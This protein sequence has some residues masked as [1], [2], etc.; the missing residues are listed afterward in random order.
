[1][2]SALSACVPAFQKQASDPTIDGCEILCGCWELVPRPLEEQ[3]VFLTTET[4]LQPLVVLF[5]T[6]ILKLFFKT[7]CGVIGVCSFWNERNWE[8][9]LFSSVLS[10]D[11]FRLT[12]KE[13]ILHDKS[14]FFFPAFPLLTPRLY[15]EALGWS[16]HVPMCS[17]PYLLGPFVLGYFSVFCG[18]FHVDCVLSNCQVWCFLITTLKPL[19]CPNR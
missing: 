13:K 2:L 16:V 14:G 3:P 12:R 18:C 11:H 15:G 6:F 10:P 4:S 19:C 1:M 17:L 9:A 7:L 8:V 5:L